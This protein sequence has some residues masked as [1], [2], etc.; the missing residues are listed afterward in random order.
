MEEIHEEVKDKNF[1]DKP[2][3]LVSH[4]KKKSSFVKVLQLQVLHTRLTFF[5][6]ARLRL[7]GKCL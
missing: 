7:I 2:L 1:N 4:F 3:A 5:Y 6:Q